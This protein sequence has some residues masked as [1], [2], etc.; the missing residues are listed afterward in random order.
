M[1]TLNPDMSWR[2]EN[3]KVHQLSMTACQRPLI[4]VLIPQMQ[5][6]KSSSHKDHTITWFYLILQV[7]NTISMCKFI[8]CSTDFG[9][10]STLKST[11]IEQQV[12]IVFAVNWHKTVLPQCSC[13]RPWQSVF[14]VPKYG[15]STEKHKCQCVNVFSI[16]KSDMSIYLSYSSWQNYW[17]C[18]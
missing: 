2:H 11:H 12:G 15:T 5:Q 17:I 14:D 18:Y 10:N 4:Q 16:P 8:M 7:P 1:L 3:P 6:H 13:H 9:Q